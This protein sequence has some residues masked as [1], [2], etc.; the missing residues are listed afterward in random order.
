MGKSCLKIP[1]DPVI[2]I[3]SVI[4]IS[5][6]PS[7]IKAKTQSMPCLLSVAIVDVPDVPGFEISSHSAPPT[8]SSA[9]VR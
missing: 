5:D 1:P 9:W 3:S 8:R 2:V 7:G 4:H 6:P